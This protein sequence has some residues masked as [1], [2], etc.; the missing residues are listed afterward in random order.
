MSNGMSKEAERRGTSPFE[1]IFHK[2]CDQSRLH[3]QPYEDVEIPLKPMGI[4]D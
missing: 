2:S 1:H 4:T 3:L